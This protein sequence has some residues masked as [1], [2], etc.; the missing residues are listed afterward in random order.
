MARINSMR[1]LKLAAF[2]DELVDKGRALIYTEIRNYSMND[3]L[4]WHKFF[5]LCLF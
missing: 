5:D 3:C 1:T 2:S 4:I